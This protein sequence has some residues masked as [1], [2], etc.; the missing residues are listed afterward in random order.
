LNFRGG[1]RKARCF[2]KKKRNEFLSLK[3][4]LDVL[5]A[6]PRKKLTFAADVR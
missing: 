4:R 1:K 5:D 2:G 6:A 3:K